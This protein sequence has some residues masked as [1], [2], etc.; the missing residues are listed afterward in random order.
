[1]DDKTRH[2]IVGFK[3][4]DKIFQKEKSGRKPNTLR[5][6]DEKD[7]RFIKLKEWHDKEVFGQ[8]IIENKTTGEIFT[9]QVK[10]VTYFDKW[11]IISWENDTLPHPKGR[12]I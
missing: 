8:I 10:D 2:E 12:G 11:V 9:R 5:L 4:W 7:E 1:M 6:H 3:S